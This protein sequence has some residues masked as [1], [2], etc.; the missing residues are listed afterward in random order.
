MKSRADGEPDLTD[1]ESLW[2]SQLSA[3]RSAADL[4]KQLA[5]EASF[6]DNELRGL[7]QMEEDGL[8][9]QTDQLA[10]QHQDTL[11]KI[12]RN[13]ILLSEQDQDAAAALAQA[14]QRRALA[15]IWAF[16][17]QREQSEAAL[18]AASGR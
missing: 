7:Q 1:T 3:D 13:R 14:N 12:R 11:L 5:I 16:Q 10:L 9:T 8:G 2:A 18:R 4:S 6:R 17:R 15:E